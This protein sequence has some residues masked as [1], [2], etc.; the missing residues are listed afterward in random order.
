VRVKKF[1]SYRGELGQI[2]LTSLNRQFT[3]SQVNQKWVT[4]VT[5]FSIAGEKL[6]LSPVMN[7]YNGEIVAYETSHWPDFSLV[8]DMLKKAAR[9]CRGMAGPL[10]HSDQGWHG[11]CSRIEWLWLDMG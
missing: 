6:Y 10:L 2:A 9:I 8:M 11:G 1:R 7:L 5:E 4:D 3:A